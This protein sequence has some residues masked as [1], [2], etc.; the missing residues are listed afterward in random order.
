MGMSLSKLWEIVKGRKPGMLQSMESQTVGQDWMTEE[1]ENTRHI[2]INV[3]LL[4]DDINPSDHGFIDAFLGTKLKA[5][6]IKEKTDIMYFIKIK[7]ICSTKDIVNRIKGQATDW[8]I[9]FAKHMSDEGQG[10]QV[11]KEL[12]KFNKKNVNIAKMGKR[13][14]KKSP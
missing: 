13:Y 7:N 14:R 11:Y 9:I 12:L 8:E 3:I 10:S 1:Q 2:K 4:E 6:S 5:W